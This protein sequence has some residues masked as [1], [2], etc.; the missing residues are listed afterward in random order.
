MKLVRRGL[1]FAPS[2]VALLATVIAP[3][4]AQTGV[5]V[6]TWHNDNWRTGQNT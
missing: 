2:V 6:T 4:L 3:L 1:A 5:N